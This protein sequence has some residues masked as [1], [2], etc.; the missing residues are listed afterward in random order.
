MATSIEKISMD[1]KAESS[2][3]KCLVETEHKPDLDGT[4]F[5]KPSGRKK[6]ILYDRE[7]LI[8][9]FHSP[10][11]AK[12]PS[13]FPI[14]HLDCTLGASKIKRLPLSAPQQAY[15]PPKR[16]EEGAK[17]DR[18]GEDNISLRPHSGNFSGGCGPNLT[19]PSHVPSTNSFS[20][21][22]AH[23]EPSKG[24][25]RDRDRDFHRNN[26][27]YGGHNRRDMNDRNRMD[28]DREMDSR[29]HRD[30]MNR[31]RL[32][33]SN[34]R[35]NNWSNDGPESD[36]SRR[37]NGAHFPRDRDYNTNSNK[38]YHDRQDEQEPEW[39]SGGPSDRHETIELR[40]FLD[41]DRRDKSDD[42]RNGFEKERLEHNGE[43]DSGGESVKNEQS[44]ENESPMDL[45]IEKI[46]KMDHIPGI[47]P[48]DMLESEEPSGSSRFSQF[49][50]RNSATPD[51]GLVRATHFD[52]HENNSH[53]NNGDKSKAVHEMGEL[54]RNMLI[55]KNAPVES[56]PEPKPKEAAKPSPATKD[57][58]DAFKKL[59]TPLLEKVLMGPAASK[60]ASSGKP[61]GGEQGQAN[62]GG[63]VMDLFKTPPQQNQQK[64]QST[65][66]PEDVPRTNPLQDIFNNMMNKQSVPVQP[67]EEVIRM[68]PN[69]ALL[70]L[71]PE[72]QQLVLNMNVSQND[73]IMLVNL[74][75]SNEWTFR[76]VLN[77]VMSTQVPPQQHM[78]YVGIFK[79]LIIGAVNL[80]GVVVINPNSQPI[81]PMP[82]PMPNHRPPNFEKIM[83]R[84]ND[85]GPKE[86]AKRS[87]TPV[88]SMAFTPTSVM[89]KMTADGGKSVPP[90]NPTGF[91]PVPISGGLLPTPPTTAPVIMNS[92]NPN[93]ASL[94]STMARPHP[95]MQFRPGPPP[96]GFPP[97]AGFHPSMMTANMHGPVMIPPQF[98]NILPNQQ[99]IYNK[100]DEN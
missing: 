38:R 3:G 70:M 49:F 60:K 37:R 94:M 87:A 41:D 26:F 79:L 61:P 80:P 53:A 96:M 84:Q 63:N 29:D 78:A 55:K 20:R 45:S 52:Q 100:S 21:I 91:V 2:S 64:S 71:P 90:Q 9:C 25:D 58:V 76:S 24:Y 51:P 73:Y 36:W 6:R 97:N 10:A 13:G 34:H 75:K 77:G 40:G 88:S 50:K 19:S 4:T 99:P 72:L 30:R 56:T 7:F 66:V 86:M 11:S 59:V 47:L 17:R 35:G 43:I 93:L 82:Q 28:R 18:D 69:Q 39:F 68:T 42:L 92:N 46:L 15:L 8:K 74:A 14:P 83:P 32:S 48:N 23:E 27:R 57:D 85:D 81:H 65:P 67:Q 1:L 31:D 22:H 5:R 89:R 33:G 12:K 95:H 98:Q 54:L 16:K 62:Q 44:G